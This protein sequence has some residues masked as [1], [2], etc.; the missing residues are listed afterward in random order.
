MSNKSAFGFYEKV[1]VCSTRP[2]LKEINGELGAVLGKAQ[3]ESGTWGYAV[4]IY[5]T[6]VVWD[7]PE[8]ELIS[9][10][11]FDVRDS[12]FSGASVRVVV[13]K[14]GSGHID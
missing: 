6:R 4:S 10:G 3:N 7:L 11:E 8:H 14:D 5:K 13:D 12:F 1:R 9:T 2:E